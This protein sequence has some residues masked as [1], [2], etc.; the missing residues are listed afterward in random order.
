MEK[1]LRMPDVMARVGVSKP[2][3]YLWIKNGAF[4]APLK[5]GPRASGWLVAEID[6]W[7]A[8]RATARVAN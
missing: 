3:I 7:I 5:I 4:P 1:I 2:T 8:D 6:A